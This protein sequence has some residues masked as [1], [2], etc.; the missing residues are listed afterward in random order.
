[1]L[2]VANAKKYMELHNYNQPSM[3][4]E[5]FISQNSTT[6][7]ILPANDYFESKI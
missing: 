7:V 6:T 2:S 3:N 1:M 4:N 5:Q